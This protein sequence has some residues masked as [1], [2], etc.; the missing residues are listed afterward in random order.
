MKIPQKKKE[1]LKACRKLSNDTAN[2]AVCFN[3]L[4]VKIPLI[5]RSNRLRSKETAARPRSFHVCASMFYHHG[6]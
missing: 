3:H 5:Q 6:Y 1:T 2:H 4:K